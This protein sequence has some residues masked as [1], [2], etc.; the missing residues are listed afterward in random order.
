MECISDTNAIP[1]TSKHQ[2]RKRNKEEGRGEAVTLVSYDDASS[3]LSSSSCVWFGF[4][5]VMI[6]EKVMVNYC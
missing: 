1:A 4:W 5:Y 6:E 2:H 3:A